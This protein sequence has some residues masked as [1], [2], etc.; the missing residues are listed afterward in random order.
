M[1][2]SGW[3]AV[4]KFPEGEFEYHR[5]G[6]GGTDAAADL[7]GD[8]ERIIT[9]TRGMIEASAQAT[10]FPDLKETAARVA[11]AAKVLASLTAD[12]L[13]ILN[14]CLPRIDR[15]RFDP[16]AKHLPTRAQ[17]ENLQLASDYFRKL[18]ADRGRPANQRALLLVESLVHA[19]RARLGA[20]P[21]ASAS[22]RNPF[23]HLVVAALVAAGISLPEPLDTIR[24]AIALSE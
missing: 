20:L 9:S 3:V 4:F 14:F 24:A 13:Q 15:D 10:P 21:E 2:I 1:T 7:L 12:D 6:F 11:K 8:V 17:I 19:H 23:Y 5:N 22:K 16:N 18:R